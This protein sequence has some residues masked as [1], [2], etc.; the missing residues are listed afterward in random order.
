M[1]KAYYYYCKIEETIVA[2]GFIAIVALIFI[3]AFLRALKMPLIWAD[4][5]AK[6][7]FSWVALIGADVAFRYSRLIGV[8]LVT[9]KLPPRIMKVVQLIVFSII[10]LFLSFLTYYGFNLAIESMDRSFQT[11]SFVS[12]SYVTFSLPVASILMILSASIKIGKTLKNF[13]NDNYN[14]LRDNETY[15]IK[16]EG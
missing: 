14:V 1:K 2:I 10:I 12:Y 7:L 6:L 8:D 5:F 9:N 11:L 13:N 3:A 16:Q 15:D 4:D